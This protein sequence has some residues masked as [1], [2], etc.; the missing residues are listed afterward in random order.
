MSL[1]EKNMMYQYLYIAR[2]MDN[3]NLKVQGNIEKINTQKK[4]IKNLNEIIYK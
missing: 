3:K 2:L 4:L 1:Y